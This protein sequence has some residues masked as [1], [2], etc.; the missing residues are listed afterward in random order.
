MYCQNGLPL[1]ISHLSDKEVSM[2]SQQPKEQ[3]DQ[4]DDLKTGGNVQTKQGEK[5]TDNAPARPSDEGQTSL[6]EPG[7]KVESRGVGPL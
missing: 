7:K 2:S 3:K 5:R 6:D 4:K 1:R